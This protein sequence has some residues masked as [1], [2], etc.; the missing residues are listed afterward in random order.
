M[1]ID[2]D[3]G[4]ITF[5]TFGD[6]RLRGLGV[7][8]VEFPISSLTC[9]VA[10]LQQSRTTVRVCDGFGLDLILQQSACLRHCLA[11][12]ALNLNLEPPTE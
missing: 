7:A 9:V 6:D 2:R 3:V 5:A 8:G 1:G 11:V 12:A 4:L 10:P